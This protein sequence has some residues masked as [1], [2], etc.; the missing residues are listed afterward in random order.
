MVMRRG[1]RHCIRHLTVRTS[2]KHRYRHLYRLLRANNTHCLRSDSKGRQARSLFTVKL[3]LKRWNGRTRTI[4]YT[5]E[6]SKNPY[7]WPI[8]KTCT[9]NVE[10]AHGIFPE[11]PDVAVPSRPRRLARDDMKFVKS[12]GMNMSCPLLQQRY[13]SNRVGQNNTIPVPLLI[14]SKGTSPTARIRD[15]YYLGYDIEYI[16]SLAISRALIISKHA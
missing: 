3:C 13:S 9:L 11:D 10:S 14:E 4:L 12:C 7:S 8:G 1:G 5:L 6:T 15:W 2:R 16:P